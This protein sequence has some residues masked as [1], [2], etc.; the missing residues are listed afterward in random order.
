M[1]CPKCG[2]NQGDGKKFCTVCGTNL[3][4][5]SQALTGQLPTVQPVVH[6]LPP[7]IPQ[8]DYDRHRETRKGIT[9]A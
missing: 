7:A 5:V 9:M 1:F 3:Q 8:I 4:L 2:S 6:T